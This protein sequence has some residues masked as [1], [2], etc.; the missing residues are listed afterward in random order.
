VASP[1]SGLQQPGAAACSLSATI[2]HI[3][4]RPNAPVTTLRRILKQRFCPDTEEVTGSNPIAHE[5]HPWS[6]G[7]RDGLDTCAAPRRKPL[8][9][10][11]LI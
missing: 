9:V 4:D 2:S 1:R 6:H 7:L 11:L 8:A 3:S 5:Q 10:K